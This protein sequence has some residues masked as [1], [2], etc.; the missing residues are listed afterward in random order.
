MRLGPI[1]LL[2]AL[3][4]AGAAAVGW[5]GR[6]EETSPGEPI[7]L[8]FADVTVVDGDTVRVRGV[9]GGERIRL[10]GF[11]APEVF[12][13]DCPDEEELGRFATASLKGMLRG[14]G[15]IELTLE[16][17]RDAYGR[18]L[19]RLEVDGRDMGERL[20]MEGLARPYDR[21]GRRG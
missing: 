17:G 10:M 4:L 5:V 19:G 15:R 11:D 14:A 20:I 13:P 8:S 18:G 12:D 9:L 16:P 21:G 6:P 3:A 1:P 2:A 7:A